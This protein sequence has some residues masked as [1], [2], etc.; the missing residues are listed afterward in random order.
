[1]MRQVQYTRFGEPTEVLEVVEAAVPEPGPGQVA[2]TL[3]AAPVHLADLKH[4]QGLPWF[5][6]YRPPQVPGY[7]GVGR[8]SR[9]GQGVSGWSVG[10]RVFLPVSFGA[11]RDV[12]I[13]PAADLWRA[14]EHIDAAQLALLPI[15]LTTAWLML[16]AIVTLK[17]GDWVMQNAA[18]SNVG[19]YIIR[20][21][22]RLGVK[23][24]NVVRSQER[25]A[26]LAAAGGDVNLVDGPDLAARVRGAIGDGAVRLAFD[27]VAGDATERL[28]ACLGEA[29]GTVAVYGLL[30]GQPCAVAPERLMF[31]DVRVVGFYTART[32]VD[33]TP[34]QH[35]EMRQSLERYLHDDPPHS[36]IAGIYPFDRVREAVAHAARTQHDRVGKIILTPNTPATAE[37]AP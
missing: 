16:D 20:L 6:G 5:D 11:W 15:N 34:D 14:P 35:R 25:V 10:D 19:Y 27:A 36:P 28:A 21:A 8:V 23:T 22:R 2:I 32:L 13:V 30:S 24:V 3:E 26:D 29:G 4:I 12:S 9:L 37:A 17:P 18:N 1:M 7:E 33:L 31:A